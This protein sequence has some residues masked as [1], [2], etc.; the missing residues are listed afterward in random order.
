[1]DK[2]VAALLASEHGDEAQMQYIDVILGSSL[3]PE[4]EADVAAVLWAAWPPLTTP[5]PVVQH[6]LRALPQQFLQCI[7]RYINNPSTEVEEEACFLWMQT[8]TRLS[9]WRSA[10]KVL[11]IFMALR[12]PA[13]SSRIH[14]V[15]Q[16]CPP[17]AFSESLLVSELCMNAQKLSEMLIKAG[18]IRLVGYA[19]MWL[20]Q[21]L[22]MLVNCEQWAVLVKGGTDVLLTAAE[23]LADRDTI[24]GA[25]VILET[26]FLGYQ[27]N[28][29]VFVA[30][31]SHFYD[32]IARWT[33]AHPPLSQKIQVQLHE[34][35]Q[36]LLFAF[37]GHPLVQ[38]HLLKITAALPSPPAT[39]NLE[40]Y[41]ES[42]RW[43]NCKQAT[44][45]PFLSEDS[46]SEPAAPR[47]RIPGVVGLKNVGNSCYMNAVLQGLF[48][49]PGLHE[50][51]S[52]VSSRRGSVVSEFQALVH[53]ARTS[54][55]SWLNATIMQRFRSSLV[56]EYQTSRQQDAA[57]FLIYLLDALGSQSDRSTA[58]TLAAIFQG[59][60]E[61]QITCDDCRA[62]SVVAED[63]TDLHVPVQG[64][65]PTLPQLLAA[66]FEPEELSE[67]LENAY[68][69]EACNA[70]RTARKTTCIRSAPQHLILSINRFQYNLQRGIREKICDPVNCSGNVTLPTTTGDVK[71][72]MYAVIVHAGSRADH[73][74]YYAYCRRPSASSG[75]APW[76]LL[77]DSQVSEVGDGLVAGMLAH[78][79]TDTPYLL[80][81]RRAPT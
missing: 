52:G 34:L 28:A 15:F 39:F 55:A 70:K 47:S 2:L 9:E 56:P 62:A 27:E 72:E 4:Q 42:R 6:G 43:K 3:T 25:L 80:F 71:Y 11:L 30:F 24:A 81:Y 5:S 26:I 17:V 14:R 63:F 37:P 32:R 20:R 73:G 59:T 13:A 36:G 21:L 18:R 67:R 53:A 22:L 16:E 41:V 61:R 79:T 64:T 29:D 78:A 40:A 50:L 60:F 35:I 8:E 58:S 77:N 69:C 49:T 66:L 7:R 75:Q 48:W 44:S 31:F 57:E 46:S 68:F 38:A 12:P 45:S 76:L 33:T 74:H 65:A 19:G 10:I 51:F 54:E 1:M 23:Q